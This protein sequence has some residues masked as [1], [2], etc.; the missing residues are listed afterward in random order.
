M[1]LAKVGRAL[2]LL[3][4]CSA[5]RL[6]TLRIARAGFLATCASIVTLQACSS[7]SGSGSSTPLG[8]PDSEV[9]LDTST[10]DDSFDV[11][12]APPDTK[13]GGDAPTESATDANDATDASS[14]G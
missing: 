5:P 14:D 12:T 13:G 4:V 1:D 2:T 10:P 8:N 7:D 9:P 3:T 6:S 11:D